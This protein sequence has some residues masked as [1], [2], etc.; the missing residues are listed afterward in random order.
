MHAFSWDW[1]LKHSAGFSEEIKHLCN[2]NN[3]FFPK[4]EKK[5]SKTKTNQPNKIP[6]TSLAMTTGQ[7][8]RLVRNPTEKDCLKLC[9]SFA[10]SQEPIF[11]MTVADKA[12]L[13]PLF[14]SYIIHISHVG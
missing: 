10:G 4:L 2:L 12:L 13:G 5:K 3:C 11:H 14:M 8:R 9:F 7:G 1:P 6:G